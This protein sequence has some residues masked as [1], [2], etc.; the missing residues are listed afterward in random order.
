MNSLELEVVS[1]TPNGGAHVK[2]ND[3]GDNLGIL[4]LDKRQLESIIS[5][6]TTGS[7]TKDV[8]FSIKNPFEEMVD[9]IPFNY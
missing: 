1:K 5:I 4:Y 7:F 9:E 3:A 2:I 8:P 6:L